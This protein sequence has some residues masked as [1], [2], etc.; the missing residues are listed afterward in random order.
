MERFPG[1]GEKVKESI[2][3]ILEYL[4]ENPEREGLK[5]TPERVLRSFERLYGGYLSC[6]KDIFTFFEE[7]KMVPVD[8][9]ILL[10]DIEFFSTCEHHMLPFIGKAHVAYIPSN[11]VVGISKLA[12][13]IEIYARRLQT[14]ER[15]GAQVTQALMDHLNPQGAACVIESSHFCMSCRGVE[16]QSSTMVT[17]SLRGAFLEESEARSELM[18]LIYH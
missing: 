2:R 14:Q 17:S 11:K 8:Q 10:R 18:K 5:N 15:I 7:E 9:I 13:L 6:P 16:K 3:L 12:R 1:N 4:G